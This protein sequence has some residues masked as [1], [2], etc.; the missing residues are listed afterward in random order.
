M[1]Q[2]LTISTIFWT[3]FFSVLLIVQIIRVHS[4][5]KCLNSEGLSSTSA[6][7]ILLCS[8]SGMLSL[9]I[10]KSFFVSSLDSSNCLSQSSIA[11]TCFLLF[12][13][14]FFCLFFKSFSWRRIF[15]LG[16]YY[17][18]SLI[19]MQ[20]FFTCKIFIFIDFTWC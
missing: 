8:L 2:I 1:H 19:K 7:N 3:Y 10:L 20:Y 13:F 12:V 4:F 18:L 5:S 17:Y 9:S 16:L 11:F 6:L 15:K 14:N